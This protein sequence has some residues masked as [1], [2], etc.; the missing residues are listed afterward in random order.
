MTLQSYHLDISFCVNTKKI[1]T[2]TDAHEIEYPRTNHFQFP[3]SPVPNKTQRW[4]AVRKYIVI[5][6]GLSVWQYNTKITKFDLFNL[7]QTVIN[8]AILVTRVLLLV[9][10][11][12]T[13]VI[14]YFFLF[15]GERGW[16]RGGLVGWFQCLS[17]YFY[18]NQERELFYFKKSHWSRLSSQR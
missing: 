15:F 5:L 12:V 9:T 11:P 13:R 18:L 1:A 16:G 2:R 3:W 4:S 14:F 7:S 6:K 17:M 10:P 8:I